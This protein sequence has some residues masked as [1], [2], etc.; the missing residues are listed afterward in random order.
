MSRLLATMTL[1]SMLMISATH[2]VT[3]Q[4]ATTDNLPPLP[5]DAKTRTQVIDKVLQEID[6][7]Y[8]F[9][10]VAEKMRQAI[11]ARVEKKEY[12]DVSTGQELAQRLTAHL[13]EVS[14]DKHLRVRCSTEKLPPEPAHGEPPPEMIAK[15]KRLTQALNAG[16]R[17][18][19]RLPGNVGYLALDGFMRA[20]VASAPVAA[21][22]TFLANTDA[23]ILDLRR[24]GGGSPDT[25]ALVCSY[26][27]DEKPIHLN[28]LYF[29]P[30]NRTDDFWTREK[31]DGPR[32]VGKPLYVLTSKYTFSGAEECAYNLQTQKR[33]TIVG[34]TTGGGAHPGG[35]ARINDHFLVFVPTGRAINP[36]TKTNW[37]GTGVKPEIAVPADQALETAHQKAIDQILEKAPSDE[38]RSMIRED[39]ED[40]KR[41]AQREKTH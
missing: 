2:M 23:L 7:N 22:M 33:A 6:E 38:A 11:Q 1:A 18:V 32:F 37:E 13:Q 14:K 25:V 9:P 30:A 31:L 24:N 29:R 19:E 26:F 16:C 8:V 41:R 20:D 35:T 17:K 5:I 3:G 15:R 27:F 10:E 40:N 36:I 34:E 4:P 28:S 39:I 12:D 21:A